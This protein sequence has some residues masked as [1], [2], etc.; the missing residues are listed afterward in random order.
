MLGSVSAYRKCPESAQ[1][2]Q[3][4]H[5]RRIHY[6]LPSVVYM[7]VNGAIYGAYAD[8]KGNC[9]GTHCFKW[10]FAI[11]AMTLGE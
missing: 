5:R 9:T 11:A 8:E 3:N 6:L 1:H 4:C 10:A 2:T 7:E